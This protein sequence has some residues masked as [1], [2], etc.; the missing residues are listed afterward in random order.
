MASS[1]ATHP[2]KKRSKDLFSRVG[3]F[4]EKGR[5]LSQRAMALPKKR[6]SFSMRPWHYH[7]TRHRLKTTSKDR[8]SRSGG[9]SEKG[10]ML[11]AEGHGPTREEERLLRATTLVLP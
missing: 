10:K 7:L 5:M 9:L 8:F 2:L 3:S 6:I 1:V 11:P 4:L